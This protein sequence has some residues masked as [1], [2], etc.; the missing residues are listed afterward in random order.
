M[1]DD[2]QTEVQ[3]EYGGDVGTPVPPHQQNVTAMAGLASAAAVPGQVEVD[4]GV[5]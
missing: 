2:E 5:D 4:G 3:R 1:K